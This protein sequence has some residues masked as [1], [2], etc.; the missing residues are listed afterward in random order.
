VLLRLN[1]TEEQTDGILHD[2]PH[3]HRLHSGCPERLETSHLGV[4]VIRLDVEIDALSARV[5][6]LDE[7]VQPPL[8]ADRCVSR[9]GQ[10]VVVAAERASPESCGDLVHIGRH[11]DADRGQAA[12][13]RHR[14]P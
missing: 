6:R 9:L 13:V 4:D 5:E 3:Q 10:P 12:P 11:V 14:V 8:P 1:D 2:P 7:R